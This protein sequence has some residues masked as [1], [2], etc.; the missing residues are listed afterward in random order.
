MVAETSLSL[1]GSADRVLIEGR[2]A[3]AA[4]FVRGL[5][6]LRPDLT[7]YT[8]NAHNDVSFGAL[9]LVE[10]DLAPSGRLARVEPLDVDLTDYWTRWLRAVER[11][12]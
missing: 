10:P 7:F 12:A 8:A 5:A 3:E 6:R 2:F 1:I 9:R 4:V 11:H